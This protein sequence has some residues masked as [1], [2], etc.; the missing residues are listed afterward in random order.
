MR[1]V[2]LDTDQTESNPQRADLARR[3]ANKN[4]ITIVWQRTCFEAVLL[5]HLPACDTHRPPDTPT[6][7]RALIQ[8]W[9]DY[10]KPMSRVALSRRIDR[11]AVSRAA[12]VVPE[13]RI[14]LSRLGLI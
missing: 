2:L 6:A 13:L 3:L 8:K 5:R 10:E 1:F 11:E 4:N 12:A 14:L 9:P 7:V